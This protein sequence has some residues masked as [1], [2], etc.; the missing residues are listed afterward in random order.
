M[1]LENNLIA[2]F[3][4]PI[5]RLRFNMRFFFFFFKALYIL[6]YSTKTNNKSLY[7]MQ[8]WVRYLL[9]TYCKYYQPSIDTLAIESA[10]ACHFL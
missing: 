3:F 8:C 9:L 6:Y 1:I 5:L 2:I 10:L 4:L 7:S